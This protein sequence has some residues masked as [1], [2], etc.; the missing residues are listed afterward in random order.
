MAKQGSVAVIVE[1]RV[2]IPEGMTGILVSNTRQALAKMSAAYFDY[3][4]QKLTF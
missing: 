3:P 1:K 4:A 2:D